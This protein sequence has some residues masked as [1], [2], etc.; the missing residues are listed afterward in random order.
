[1]LYAGGNDINNGKTP[2]QVAS[3]FRAFVEKVRQRQPE[4]AIDYI[5]IAPN[6]ARW[7]QIEKVR[8]ANELIAAKVATT[9]TKSSQ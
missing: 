7:A 4:V 1:M 9:E 6:P 8:K 2:E 5:S 3:D